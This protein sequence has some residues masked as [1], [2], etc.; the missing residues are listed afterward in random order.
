MLAT[1]HSG[2]IQF[3]HYKSKNCEFALEINLYKK[4]K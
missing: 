4:K 3:Q 1:F 2:M